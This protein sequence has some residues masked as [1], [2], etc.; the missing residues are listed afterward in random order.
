MKNN[1]LKP[2]I[3]FFIIASTVY[4]CAEDEISIPDLDNEIE[5]I[6]NDGMDDEKDAE[7]T[8]FTVTELSQIVPFY[9]GDVIAFAD[10]SILPEA[11]MTKG[12]VISNDSKKNINHE[13]Y[14]QDKALNPTGG[15]VI[16]VAVDDIYR[17][18]GVGQEI[19]V[20]LAGLGMQK[21]GST[22]H[23]GTY[24]KVSKSITPISS[25]QF[26]THIIKTDIT[27]T[28]V[29]KVLTIQQ[30]LESTDPNAL[31]TTLPT[32]LVT[33]ENIQLREDQLGSTYADVDNTISVNGSHVIKAL[34]DCDSGL[35]IDLQN[36]ISSNF[37]SR[38]FPNEQGTITG[39]LSSNTLIIREIDD[40]VFEETRCE[41]VENV[42]DPGVLLSEDFQSIS[43]I[44][45]II[46]LNG[47]E[48]M[49]IS[50]PQLLKFWISNMTDTDAFAE[51]EQG[52]ATTNY[53]AWLI[54]KEIEIDQ[55]R[56]L[57]LTFDINVHKH[58]SDNLKLFIID[59]VTGDIIDFDEAN[60]IEDVVPLNNTEGFNT[61]ELTITIPENLDQFRIGFRYK[62]G[63][64]AATTEYQ[65]DNIIL[66]E[67]PVQ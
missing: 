30:A 12:F 13:I 21:I 8:N 6:T 44:G 10:T 53:D 66:T 65:I 48:N 43:K 24:D 39:I 7:I 25:D 45:E 31:N 32:I 40:I 34:T 3:A 9:N 63:S 23:I 42:L 58:N 4:S 29:P 19:Q 64:T 47:W 37:N 35:S 46:S 18:L 15:V 33:L 62:K 36:S 50:N 41:I 54:T 67:D 28:I 38:A 59:N 22:I 55:V 57:K 26:D 61:Q 27:E 11:L 5:E 17:T 14:I 20:K 49:N 1:L 52:G 60:E 51:I 2:I 56:T 16:D